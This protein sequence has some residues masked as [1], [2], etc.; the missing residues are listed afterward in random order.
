LK[1]VRK[2]VDY[3]HQNSPNLVCVV[4][5]TGTPYFKRQPLRDVVV[6]YGLSLGHRRQHSQIGGLLL[7]GDSKLAA[8]GEVSM[9]AK[10]GMME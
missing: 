9:L 10:I 6:W 5:T 8:P 2:T 4:N 3:L 1:K 7:V